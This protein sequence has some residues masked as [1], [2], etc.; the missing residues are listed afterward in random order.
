MYTAPVAGIYQ[1][2]AYIRSMP[3]ANFHLRVDGSTYVNPKHNYGSENAEG[4]VEGVSVTVKLEVGQKV[5]ITTGSGNY[6][7]VG[8]TNGVS[9]WFGGYLVFPDTK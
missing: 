9:T 8:S 2:F 4:E 5:H 1:F 3:K 6:T 7:V